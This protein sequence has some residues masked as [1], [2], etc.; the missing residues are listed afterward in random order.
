MKIHLHS[1]NLKGGQFPDAQ[2]F[3]S[4]MQYNIIHHTTLLELERSV[5]S[6]V[7]K[8]SGKLCHA[9]IKAVLQSDHLLFVQKSVN[10]NEC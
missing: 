2:I 8:L 9:A 10:H 1:E 4:V 6:D 3:S 5:N 7:I